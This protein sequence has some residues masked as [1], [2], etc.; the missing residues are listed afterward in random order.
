M[1]SKAGSA[2]ATHS[3]PATCWPA[4]QFAPSVCLRS[5]A[6]RFRRNFVEPLLNALAH[7]YFQGV[8]LGYGVD[9]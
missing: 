6:N 3:G 8:I 9:S 4:C 5:R 7:L 1:A 2:Q